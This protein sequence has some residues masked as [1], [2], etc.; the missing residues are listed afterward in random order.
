MVT[1]ESQCCQN[2]RC[3][4]P[5]CPLE[6]ELKPPE[7]EKHFP[8]NKRVERQVRDEVR[9][10]SLCGF[11]QRESH[12][13]GE[14]EREDKRD[15]NAAPSDAKSSQTFTTLNQNHPS[16]QRSI[17]QKVTESDE[18]H[19]KYPWRLLTPPKVGLVDD[20]EDQRCPKGN[21]SIKLRLP[22]ERT[23]G[24]RIRIRGCHES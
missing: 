24:S 13:P 20:W 18:H 10:S 21:G 5:E 9:V 8:Q 15:A 11:P 3:D 23:A 6:P 2:W 16:G 7:D 4:V 17:E 14:H 1:S 19:K 12:R 22:R